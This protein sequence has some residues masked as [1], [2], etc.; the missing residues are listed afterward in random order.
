[1]EAAV[2]SGV[3]CESKTIGPKTIGSAE[4]AVEYPTTV[5]ERRIWITECVDVAT[6]KVGI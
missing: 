4:T 1:V 6:D 3:Q 5:E 2:E